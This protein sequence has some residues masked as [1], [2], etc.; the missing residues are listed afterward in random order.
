M[1]W[2]V[3]KISAYRRRAGIITVFVMI[4]YLFSGLGIFCAD[5]SLAQFRTHGMDNSSAV[6]VTPPDRDNGEV[7]AGASG[8]RDRKGGTLPC[9]CKKKKKCP[10]IPRAAIISNPTHRSSEF[11]RLAKSD[12]WD[13][14]VS[15]TMDIHFVTRGNTPLLE[16]AWRSSFFSSPPLAL[17]CVLLI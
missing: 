17:T 10:A 15:Q 1:S 6:A 8:N 14:L 16:L 5:A 9:S 13:A 3:N 2:N 4:S 7:S 11:Q 12:C